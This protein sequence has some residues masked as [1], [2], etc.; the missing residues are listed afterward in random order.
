MAR[1]PHRGAIPRPYAFAG[2]LLALL[3]L[4]GDLQEE[5]LAAGSG[6]S[7]DQ[8]LD[9]LGLRFDGEEGEAEGDEAED[10]V[11]S[12]EVEFVEEAADVSVVGSA[13]RVMGGWAQ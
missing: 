11:D 7:Q 9:F 3:G 13:Q 1:P 5:A 8:V 6:F 4:S 10:L 12:E 2:A